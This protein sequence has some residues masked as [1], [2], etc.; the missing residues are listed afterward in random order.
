MV[1]LLKITKNIKLY[2]F[3]FNLFPYALLCTVD[4]VLSFSS[5]G[6]NSKQ[7]I[8]TLNKLCNSENTFGKHVFC[9]IDTGLEIPSLI[10]KEYKRKDKLFRDEKF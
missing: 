3:I 5:M 10:I 4:S 1:R 2:Q 8:V 9:L 7:N 6:L